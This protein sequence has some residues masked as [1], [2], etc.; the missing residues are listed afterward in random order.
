MS[1]WFITGCS[2]G[3][4]RAL[5]ERA[6]HA[7]H[8]VALT[9][10]DPRTLEPLVQSF[11]GR[12]IGLQLD[13]RDHHR[14][15]E[16]IDEASTA[17]GPID[18]LVNNAGHG[19]RAAIEEGELDRVRDLFETNFLGPISLVQAVLPH[20]RERQ[21]GTIVNVSSTAGFTAAA[22]SGFYA[23]SK[24]ALELA[25][26]A[27][28]AEVEPLGIKVIVV[29]PGGFRTEFAGRSLQQ[30]ESS[31]SAYAETAGRR[32][33]ETDSTHGTQPGDP[34]RAA[35]VLVEL[36]DSAQAPSRILLGSDAVQ[37]GQEQ[38]HTRLSDIQEWA[39]TSISTDIVP[40]SSN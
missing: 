22:G 13:V 15:V 12:A 38:A 28:R 32:R 37:L 24:A 30:S 31:I 8:S 26:D 18:V 10:R 40:S 33:K 1:N 21:S 25:S 11:T 27:L 5:A 36:V 6:L 34:E 4:G 17:L 7:G 3:L 16:A 9:A 14:A 39:D 23:A 35:S 2:A 20:M 29:Q 19:Y